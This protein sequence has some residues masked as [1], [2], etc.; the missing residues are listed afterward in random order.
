[1][2]DNIDVRLIG[3][4]TVELNEQGPPG[5]PG[6]GISSV[7]EVAYD[8]NTEIHTYRITYTDDTYYDFNIQGG[9][10]YIGGNGI[11]INGNIISINTNVVATKDDLEY[12]QDKLSAGE[13]ISISE[14][15]V[16]SNTR[17]SAEWGNIQGNIQD[18]TD[19]QNAL[20]NKSTV[21]IVDWTV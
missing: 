14:D 13:G 20:S 12:K 4:Y 15:N 11:T 17:I 7:S 1:M 21:T 5:A 19:L 6:L 2:S 18:Q 16:I 10:L 8:E 3:N 9:R